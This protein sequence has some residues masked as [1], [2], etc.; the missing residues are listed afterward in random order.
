MEAV[1]QE[2]NVSPRYRVLKKWMLKPA[3]LFDKTIAEMYEMLYQSEFEYIFDSSKFQNTFHMNP[4]S[5]LEGI[6]KTAGYY[7]TELQLKQ[8]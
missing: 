3:G 4:S 8:F 1:A 5:Y 6:K 7:K 2:F